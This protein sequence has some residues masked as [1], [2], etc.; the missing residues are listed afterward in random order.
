MKLKNVSRLILF[1]SIFLTSFLSACVEEIDSRHFNQRQVVVNCILT[2]D[3]VQHLSLTYSNELHNTIY[4]EV[5][6]ATALLYEDGNLIGSF[7]K[8]A[9]AE[10]VLKY[11]P[12]FGR[13]YRLEVKVDGKETIYAETKFPVEIRVLRE[14]ERDTNGK[15]AFNVSSEK[16]YW[17]FSF[18]KGEDTIM[19][20][21]VIED[22]FRFI[23]EI[24]TDCPDADD[25]NK[26]VYD[27]EFAGLY[28][29]YI[30]IVPSQI[31]QTF[32]LYDLY[33][34]VVF[35]RCVSDEYD[36][37]LKSSLLKMM[38]FSSTDDPTQWLDET[39]VY[40]N[41]KNGLGIF[42]AYHDIKINC[43]SY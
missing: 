7:K 23:T 41:I 18:D 9:Y 29:R 31:G 3:S 20:P 36:K 19:H 17:V 30:R 10:W 14:Y 28:D 2:S 27:E 16:P 22:R 37:Y 35:F 11:R 43:N 32:R 24:G 5:E 34:C 15:L 1:F 33:S 13:N 38:V 25:F 4:D 6:D 39:V 26:Y 40:N 21:I 42:G 12:K 8:S